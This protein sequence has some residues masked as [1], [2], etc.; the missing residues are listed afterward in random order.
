MGH[1]V[2]DFR[3]PA[4]G[5]KGFAWSEID[6]NW[7]NWTPEEFCAALRHPVAQDGFAKD[8]QALARCRV[9]VLVLPCGRSAH[10]EA[11]WAAGSGKPVFFLM[12]EPNEPEL[13][14]LLGTKI[15]T[16]IDELDAV[17]AYDLASS[18]AGE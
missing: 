7:L 10:L 18:R 6:P 11:G 3:N 4:P 9:C 13:M 15:L 16:G 2:Y 12:L 17:K 1:E 5:D 8:A 14:Y